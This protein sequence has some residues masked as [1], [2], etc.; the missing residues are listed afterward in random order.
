MPLTEQIIIDEKRV[1]YQ[2]WQETGEMWLLSRGETGTALLVHQDMKASE[3]LPAPRR[4]AKRGEPVSLD[5]LGIGKLDLNAPLPELNLPDAGPK[6]D[7][8]TGP[9]ATE[10]HSE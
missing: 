4:A 10:K 7:E 9:N 6:K 8:P 5:D 2:I 1:D 3:T